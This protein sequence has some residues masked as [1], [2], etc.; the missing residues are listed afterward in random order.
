[1][2]HERNKKIFLTPMVE[3]A[4]TGPSPVAAHSWSRPI[5]IIFPENL[6]MKPM[7]THMRHG[8]SGENPAGQMHLP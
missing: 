3:F 4:A 5:L 8:E 7:E 6:P 2:A 1:L